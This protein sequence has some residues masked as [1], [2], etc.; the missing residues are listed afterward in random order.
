M[1][2]KDVQDDAESRRDPVPA[3]D[4][5]H[6]GA[7]TIETFSVVYDRDGAAAFG[8]VVG[9]TAA[10]TRV[11]GKVLGDDAATLDQLLSLDRSPVGDAG[12]VSVGDDG[13]QI[14][15]A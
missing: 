8:G 4:L 13:L 5:A 6:V 10:G 9:R 3:L 14:W 12:T 1:L 11:F 15:R 2:P 7:A